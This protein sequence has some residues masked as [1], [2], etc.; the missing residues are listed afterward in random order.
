MSL[1]FVFGILIDHG[2]VKEN[3]RRRIRT[4]MRRQKEDPNWYEAKSDA[5]EIGM[6][7]EKRA[8]MYIPTTGE[9]FPDKEKIAA[10]FFH[11]SFTYPWLT[12]FCDIVRQCGCT[13]YVKPNDGP[14][15]SIDDIRGHEAPRFF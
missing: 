10:A 9:V 13:I 12:H 14:A 15:L 4:I 2:L 6:M 7:L 5:H 1:S 3:C 11:E 8:E